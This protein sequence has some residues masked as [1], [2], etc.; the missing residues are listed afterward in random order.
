MIG[1]DNEEKLLSLANISTVWVEEAFEVSQDMVEQLN[2]R[3]RG[4]AKNQEI[5]LSFNP[6]SQNH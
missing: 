6:I 1:L 3:M 2:L 4:K 5:I